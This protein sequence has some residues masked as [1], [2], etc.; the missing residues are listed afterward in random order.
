MQDKAKWAVLFAL[1]AANLFFLA[2]SYRTTKRSISEETRVTFYVDSAWSKG[3]GEINTLQNDVIYFGRTT[4]GEVHTA[5]SRLSVG[6]SF[7]Y[8]Y[9]RI[10]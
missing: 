3:P 7:V 4:D 1:L 8:V 9:R 5:K 10:Y 2:R 6:D